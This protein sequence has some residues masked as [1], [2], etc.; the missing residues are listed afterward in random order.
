MQK[1]ALWGGIGFLIYFVSQ[2]PNVAGDG[3]RAI[4]DLTLTVANG[5]ADFAG[6]L[7]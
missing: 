3:V 1:V 4:V 7:I 5:L 2:R 6:G